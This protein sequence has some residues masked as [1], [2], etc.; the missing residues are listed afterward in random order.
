MRAV[1]R[2]RALLVLGV[3]CSFRAPAAT[4]DASAPSP[5]DASPDARAMIAPLEVQWLGV[6]GFVL[7]RGHDAVMTAPLFTRQSEIDIGLGATITPDASAID[8]HLAGVPLDELRAVIT[9]HAHYDHLLDVPHV[10]D[11]APASVLV[12]NLTA[13]HILAALAP[14]HPLHCDSFPDPIILDRDRVIAMDDPL[15]SHTD[16]TN[17]PMQ[18]PAGAPLAGTWLALPGGRARALAF[19]SMHPAQ[20]GGIYHFAEGSIDS[21]LCDVPKPA[22]GWL[23]GQTLAY[24]IDFL[25]DHGSP[26]FR[27]Y[28]QDAPTN[29]PLGHVPETFLND[30]PVDLALLNV[31]SYDVVANQPQDIIANVRPRFAI[32]GHWEDFFQPLDQPLAPLPFLDVQTYVTRADDAMPGPADPPLV[33]DGEPTTARHVLAHPQLDV[34]VSPAP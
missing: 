12:A 7:R 25:D 6:Q 2:M 5:D 17:C 27:V 24:L 15:A 31:G 21:D 3:G 30:K 1:M 11:R 13:R 29:A 18:A 4:I 22:S 33:V 23:E 9:G 14:D 8:S 26:V 10:L 19:C 20:I 28:Y 32:S 16:Y 34:I